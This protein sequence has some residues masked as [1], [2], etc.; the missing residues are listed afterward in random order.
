VAEFTHQKKPSFDVDDSFFSHYETSI[1]NNFQDDNYTLHY[2]NWQCVVYTLY[3]FFK[4]N[5]TAPFQNMGLNIIS[6]HLLTAPKS[7]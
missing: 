2:S 3:C 7:F 1:Y 4:K 6:P 5:C